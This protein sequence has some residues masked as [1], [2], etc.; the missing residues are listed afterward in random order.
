MSSDEVGVDP[1]RVSQAA[2]ALENL[3][4]VLAAN[5]PTIVNTMQEYWS[6]GAGSPISLAPLQQAQSRSPE[7]ATDMR[8]RAELA[9]AWLAQSVNLAGTGMVNIPWGNTPATLSELD[10]LDAQAQAQ[11]LTAA[12]A[13]SG[14][15]PQA[16]RAEIP[17]SSSTSPTTPSRATPLADAVL[18]SGRA[19]G[20]QPG[21]HAEL[22]RRPAHG[23]AQPAGPADPQ[24]LRDRPGLRG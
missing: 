11:A 1:G 2:G 24:H 23:G 5:V 14:K 22:P 17:R 4:D 18:H 20:G 16:A 12:E 19:V 6:S 13:E 8:T 3:R 15:N 7:D 10:Q 21:R 9:A